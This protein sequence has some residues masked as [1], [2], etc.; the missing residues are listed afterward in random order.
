MKK[1]FL[2]I[3]LS[4]C[5][6]LAMVPA[7]AFTAPAKAADP[8]MPGGVISD[9]TTA[10]LDAAL[11]AGN[12]E[13]NTTTSPYTIDL[14]GNV[15]FKLSNSLTVGA[16]CIINTH[17]STL[18]RGLTTTPGTGTG[19]VLIIGESGGTAVN[20]T[21]PFNY[22]TK[23]TGGYAADGAGVKIV[24][25]TLSTRGINITGNTATGNGG[26]VYVASGS[27]FN[28]QDSY[29]KS[30]NAANGGGVYIATGGK[31]TSTEAAIGGQGTDAN[32]VSSNGGGI[33]V[34]GIFELAKNGS[35]NNG[36]MV[37]VNKKGNVNGANNNI[38]LPTGKR[39]TIADG[40]TLKPYND[41]IGQLFVTTEVAPT[42]TT[43][44]TI[45][46]ANA[47]DYANVFMGDNDSDGDSYI[48]HAYSE[49]EGSKWKI[50][51][52][53]KAP[54]TA[55]TIELKPQSTTVDAG[56]DIVYDVILKQTNNYS[57]TYVQTAQN[58]SCAVSY[59]QLLQYKYRTGLMSVSNNATKGRLSINCNYGWVKKN[60]AYT[61][62]SVI[63]TAP[64]NAATI[65]NGTNG[66]Y[67]IKDY[68]VVDAYSMILLRGFRNGQSVT[69]ASNPTQAD[70]LAGWLV[71]FNSN[72]GS[73]VAD[74][75]ASRGGKVTKPADPTKSG[76]T[77]AG[78]YS[79]Q[80]LTTK[81]DFDSAVNA[82]TTL[83][84]KWTTN[85]APSSDYKVDLVGNGGSGTGLSSYTA[86]TETALPTDW[87]KS[88][89]TF[90]G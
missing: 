48:D 68:S 49:A 75:Y 51:L 30:N 29:I 45:V 78:W 64:D 7:I 52:T 87:T 36:T 57:F 3:V 46:D 80:A 11:G 50:N 1:R 31:M 32:I 41:D 22:S 4:V 28:A 84:A 15:T 58:S 77:F 26:G 20:V 9:F 47:Y 43:P 54:T 16:D 44:V 34:G 79:D 81:Y 42:D 6:A 55:F 67:R 53:S 17:G 73:T 74:A 85:P 65:T 70:V 12:Y 76:S 61:L 63:F 60:T 62:C 59:D 40:C 89:C 69:L 86:G 24:N 66:I 35:S 2:T 71:Q 56:E 21:I 8:I 83:Y 14:D 37:S 10:T 23:I 82:A 72:G 27:T 90:A 33:Y 18:D 13:V 88:G 5:V 19:N 39:I 25:G 38:Y